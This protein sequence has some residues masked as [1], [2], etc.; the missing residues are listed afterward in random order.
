MPSNKIDQTMA[1]TAKKKA[2][3]LEELSKRKPI[4]RAT[5]PLKN[6]F[7]EL[8]PDETEPSSETIQNTK[9]SRIKIPPLFLQ[10]LGQ[11]PRWTE[12]S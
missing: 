2:L 5:L 9:S 4:L 3:L 12:N 11:I 8:K 6:R 1:D 10:N 7:D